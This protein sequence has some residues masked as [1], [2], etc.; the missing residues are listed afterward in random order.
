MRETSFAVIVELLLLLFIESALYVIAEGVTADIPVELLLLLVTLALVVFVIPLSHLHN[1][2][3][4]SP[5]ELKL[6][7]PASIIPFNGARV[8]VELV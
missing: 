1:V 6:S 3:W 7:I 4:L 2:T 8:P 5:L